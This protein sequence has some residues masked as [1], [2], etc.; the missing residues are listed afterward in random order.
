MDEAFLLEIALILV[1]TKVFGLLTRKINLPQVVGALLAGI[2]LGPTC[3]KLINSSDLM[4]T[5]SSIGVIMLMFSAGMETNLT[6]LRKSL[7]ASLVIAGIGVVIPLMGG[8]LLSRYYHENILR[9][10]FI[11]VI[12]TATS[13]SITVETLHELGKFQTKSGTVILGAAVIDDILGIIILTIIIGLGDSGDY[14][15]LAVGLVLLKIAA[16]FIFAL[17]V[18]WLAFKL[19]SYLYNKWGTLRRLSIFSLAFCFF[20]SFIAEQFGVADITGA[21]LAGLVLCGNKFVYYVEERTIILSYLFFSPIFFASIGLKTNLNGFGASVLMFSTLLLVIAIASKI[22]GC[23]LGAK[24]CGYTSSESLQIGVG[25]ISRG[26]V[27]LI[28]ADKGIAANL[29]DPLLFSGIIVVVI[30]TTL[31]TPLLLKIVYKENPPPP[32]PA[33][34]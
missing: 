11:G 27:A 16:F 8:F 10:V 17:V 23:G 5:L 32:A 29:M 18:G 14:S 30:I 25:M 1:F 3:F 4:N 6:E 7:K 19:F 21:Y 22:V 33:S 24:I 15:A 20:M 9:S 31:I 12:L 34:S 2:L 28:V 13:V 26:E